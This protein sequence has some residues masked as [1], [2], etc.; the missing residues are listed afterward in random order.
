MAAEK[1]TV[2]IDPAQ[3]KAQKQN[4]YSLYL[5]KKVNGVLP[6]FGN[7]KALSPR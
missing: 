6:L 5:A 7:Q 4:N 1:I 2:Y 3:I